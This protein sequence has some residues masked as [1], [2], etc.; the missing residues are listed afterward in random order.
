MRALWNCLKNSKSREAG[1]SVGSSL[2]PCAARRASASASD[3]PCGPV[4]SAEI[5]SSTVRACQGRGSFGIG[6]AFSDVGEEHVLHADA[7][8]EE[9]AFE[10]LLG[11][12]L[13]LVAARRADVGVRIARGDHAHAAADGG[14]HDLLDEVVADVLPDH[15]DLL[16]VEA[17]K[18]GAFDLDALAVGGLRDER[19]VAERL[20][21]LRPELVGDGIF[22]RLRVEQ[23]GFLP[24]RDLEVKARHH[25]LLQHAAAEVVDAGHVAGGHVDEKPLEDVLDDE[26]IHHLVETVGHSLCLIVET[27]REKAMEVRTNSDLTMGKMDNTTT[28]NRGKA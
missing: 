14:A 17:Q 21:V 12:D 25:D 15:R 19:H 28:E 18:D 8:R 11:L 5:A 24:E 26:R 6:G 23:L 13:D 1:A 9:D 2:G 16:D 20:H 22:E 27:A 4:P 10:L 7:A 3:R